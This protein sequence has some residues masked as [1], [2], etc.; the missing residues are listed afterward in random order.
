M[1]TSYLLIFQL[2]QI[3]EFGSDERIVADRHHKSTHHNNTREA[4]Q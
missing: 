3:S 2:P 4:N 1:A